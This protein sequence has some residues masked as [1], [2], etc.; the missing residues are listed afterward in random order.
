MT[1]KSPGFLLDEEGFFIKKWIGF[2]V[3]FPQPGGRIIP[4]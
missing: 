1:V 4:A 3:D 2:E